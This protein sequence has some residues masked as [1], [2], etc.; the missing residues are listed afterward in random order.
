MSWSTIIAT[1][2]GEF[3]YW[4][5]VQDSESFAG[6]VIYLA[7]PL[8]LVFINAFSIEVRSSEKCRRQDST[9]S[10]LD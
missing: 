2:A 1:S 8:V 6:A 7:I 4:K 3:N 5:S 9:Q 10:Q